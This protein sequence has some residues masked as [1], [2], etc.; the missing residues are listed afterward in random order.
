[1]AAPSKA[2]ASSADDGGAC[3]LPSVVVIV[4][5]FY[6]SLIDIRYDRFGRAALFHGCFVFCGTA[7]WFSLFTI[8][9]TETPKTPLS[10]NLP[11]PLP[12][13]RD[14]LLLQWL[15]PSVQSVFLLC[16]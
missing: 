3:S 7:F 12:W 2:A 1:M 16:F 6:Y 14:V 9:K 5:S 13:P 11:R 4:L 10:C 15:A 8:R